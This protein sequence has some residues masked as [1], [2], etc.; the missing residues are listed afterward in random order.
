MGVNIEKTKECFRAF[1]IFVRNVL[2]MRYPLWL[3]IVVYL[4]AVLIGSLI[5]CSAVKQQKSLMVAH[6]FD[7]N[8][9]NYLA[10]EFDGCTT[11][12]HDPECIC[13]VI[14]NDE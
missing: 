14:L 6:S 4:A 11:T 12:I 10:F 13:Y 1:I 2:T 3:F 9:H 5:A 7:Y 8:G